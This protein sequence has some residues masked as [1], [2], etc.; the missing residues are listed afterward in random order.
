MRYRKAMTAPLI[1]AT[2]VLA[3]CGSLGST[4]SP[5]AAQPSSA[6]APSSSPAPCLTRACIAGD[7]GQS[8]DGTAAKDG[9][10]FTKVTCK[11]SSV[12]RDAGDTY[13]AR[14]TAI[15]SDGS[16][17]SG[18]G[19]LLTSQDQVTFEPETQLRTGS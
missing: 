15:Y 6:P 1:A 3:G 16:E 10:V 19:S 18:Y 8:L 5:P 13:T 17:W 2:A 14:C 11:A 12:K 9:S 7:I 4:A